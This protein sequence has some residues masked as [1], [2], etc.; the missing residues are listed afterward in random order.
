MIHNISERW[1][2]SKGMKWNGIKEDKTVMKERNEGRS[3]ANN[4]YR[5][6]D[7]WTESDRER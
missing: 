1:K 4:K 2:D 6:K 7:R 3:E 5:G